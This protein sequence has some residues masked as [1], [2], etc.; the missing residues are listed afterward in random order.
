MF[1]R[2]WSFWCVLLTLCLSARGLEIS[3]FHSTDVICSQE[4]SGCVME[5]AL[6]HTTTE[7]N[8]NIR[9]IKPDFK[10]CCKDG[11]TCSLCLVIDTEL[12]IPLDKVLEDGGHSGAD[13]EDYGEE[14]RN[15]KASVTV[16]YRAAATLDT[17]KKVEF[18]VNYTALAHQNQAKVSMVI[19]RPDGFPYGSRIHTY[20]PKEMFTRKEVSAPSLDEVCAQHRL[21]KHIA[22]CSVPRVDNVINRTTNQMELLFEG[23]NDTLPSLCVQYE[24]D[25]CCKNWNKMT[26]PLYSLAP[27]M[28]LQAW[29]EDDQ[30]S[31][32]TL[33]CPF[34]KT[35]FPHDLRQAM[36]KNVSVNVRL[37]KM[38]DQSTMLLWNLTA[39]CRLEGE[40][41]LCHKTGSCREARIL[42][43]QLA[44]DKWRQNSKGL[45]ENEGAF[46]NFTE[47]FS[48]CVMV[49]IKGMEHEFG[50]VC[51]HGTAR[52]HWS[53]LVVCVML[54]VCLTALAIYFLHDVVKKCV[55][56]WHHGGCVKIGRKGHIVLL[57]PPD[58]DDGVSEAVCQLGSFLCSQGFSVSVDQWSRKEQ[59]TLGPLTWLHSQLLKL[60][61]MGGRV[62]LVL[63]HKASE[64]TEE[65]THWSKNEEVKNS[66][67]LKSP[68]SDLFS[69]SLVLI[70][71]N[72][73]LGRA[74]ERF[75]LVKFDSHPTQ[76]HN[77]DKSLPGLLQG[78]PLF[79]LPSQTQSLLS[80]LT[81]VQETG[82]SGKT[83]T[84]WRWG[85]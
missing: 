30:K 34:R 17:C 67:E 55:W 14:M 57:S 49:K 19:T 16:C 64:R 63:T 1:L 74:D 50:P 22:L 18:T 81:V 25:G 42:R 37:S 31:R 82:S 24:E 73:Q 65:W 7:D 15:H 75:V 60:D 9:K 33:Y 39:P 10:L 21:Q 58:V 79:Q 41:R 48:T 78:L 44:N 76:R 62:L 52:S 47:H 46:P 2:G 27:C 53:L 70:Q 69:G 66:Q 71:A 8:V 11:T 43:Q 84:G 40:V 36:W 54:L 56:S 77:G 80:E 20:S 4:L 12:D 83:W 61:S 38:N 45:W 68:Y 3:G 28:C 13:E 6:P 51:F 23:R 59:C 26:I 85:T 29:D 32:R 35:D 72:R 5:D